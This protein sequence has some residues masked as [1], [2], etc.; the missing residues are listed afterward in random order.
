MYHET[1]LKENL[2][3]TCKSHFIKE[4]DKNSWGKKCM[5]IYVKN[6]LNIFYTT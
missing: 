4:G 2:P 6:V 1:L 3:E 5:A